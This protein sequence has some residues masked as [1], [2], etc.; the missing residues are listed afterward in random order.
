MFSLDKLDEQQYGRLCETISANAFY[1]IVGDAL[2]RGDELS[3]VRM[4]DGERRLLIDCIEN[5]DT[6]PLVGFGEP[7][8]TRMGCAGI[9]PAE[10]NKRLNWAA[11]ECTYFAPSLSGI[12]NPEY[13]LYSFGSRFRFVDNFFPNLWTDEMKI[14][15]YKKAGHVLFIHNNPNSAK[16]LTLRLKWVLDVKVT[17][18]KLEKWQ[19]AEGVIAAAAEC[20]APLAIFSAG[21]ASKYIGPRIASNRSYPKVA[22]DIGQ[23]SDRWLLEHLH[24]QALEKESAHV[25]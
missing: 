9:S 18:L 4:A 6:Y 11:Q 16:A 10:L 1:M 20:D 7:W 3:V 19:D 17:W 23:A 8:M 13:D 14:A 15:L 24:Q 25:G 12:H 21:P 2:S 5:P 22:L